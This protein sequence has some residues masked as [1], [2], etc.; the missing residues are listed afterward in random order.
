M[1]SMFEECL[2]LTSLDLTSFNTSN[3]TNMKYMFFWCKRLTSLDISNFNTSKVKNMTS[4]FHG[5]NSLAIIYISDKW[6]TGKVTESSNLFYNCTSLV[7]GAGTTYNSNYID[8]T[9]A[10]VDGGPNSE[11]PGYLTLKSST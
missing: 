11:T 1:N 4:M 8:K 3:V 10:R 2:A 6:N 5:S 7:G 9:Y